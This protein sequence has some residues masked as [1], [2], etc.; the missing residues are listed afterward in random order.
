MRTQ[1]CSYYFDLLSLIL[2]QARAFEDHAC[3]MRAGELWWS[4][5]N[6]R[7]E[8]NDWPSMNVELTRPDTTKDSFRRLDQGVT[9]LAT[10][11]LDVDGTVASWTAGAEHIEGYAAEEIIGRD[12]SVFFTEADRRLG[13]PLA[14][15]ESARANGRADWDGWRVRKDGSRFRAHVVVDTIRDRTGELTG[16]AMVTRDTSVQRRLEVRFRQAVE[17]AP[18]GMVM[19]NAAGRIEMV[20]TSAERMFGYSREALL[21]QPI[22][23]LVP[24]RF[25]RRH[26]GL[27]GSFFR[28]PQSRAMGMGRDLYAL[29][30][31]GSEFPAEIG[32]NQIETAEGTM[33]LSTII[34]ISDRKQKEDR[35]K[36]ALKE[37][38]IL[39][40]EIHHR[41]KNNLQI[42]YSLLD[43]ESFRLEDKMA[44]SLL[45]ESKNRVRSMALIHQML[46]ESKEFARVDFRRFL[47]SLVARLVASYGSDTGRIALSINA[48]EVHLPISVAIPCGLVVNELISN[49]LKHA[50]SGDA[51]GEIKIDLASEAADRAVLSVS[52]DGVGIPEAC[53]IEQAG[54][55]GLQLVTLLAEQIG[56]DLTIRRSA[57]TRF[58]LRFP[59]PPSG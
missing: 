40:G 20:N 1:L 14:V 37:K 52:D 59:I 23:M 30:K 47:E 10:F 58:E 16:F 34:D 25:R 48:V 13:Q 45:T 53:N 12:V 57:P 7:P 4:I 42:V 18:N 19:I 2:T 31:D 46:Y 56:A 29:R 26:A 49:A 32:L 15:L 41:V 54:T 3:A 36:A 39:L 38:D 11:T 22:E 21:G 24:P 28:P 6:I 35:I 50:F 33:V 27:T 55:L 51:R 17:S 44:A 5:N 8:D 43:L 9:G